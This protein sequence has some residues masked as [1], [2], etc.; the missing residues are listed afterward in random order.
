MFT[1][2]FR[3]E[4]RENL[5]DRAKTDNRIVSAAVVGSYALGHEDQWSDIDL[6]FGFDESY[7]M[8]ALLE[9][10]TVYVKEKFA[11]HVLLDVQRLTTTYRVFLLP[12]CL[13]LDISFTP[14][15]EFGAMGPNFRL[16]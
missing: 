13:Q 3:Q 9:S 1:P 4:V 6:T 16:L 12:G 10:W 15:S 11:G 2:Q 8:D 5:L 14:A 7:A